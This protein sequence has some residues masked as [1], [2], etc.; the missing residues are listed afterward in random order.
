MKVNLIPK[1]I[2]VLTRCNTIFA[3]VKLSIGNKNIAS[4]FIHGTK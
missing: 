3:L 4:N 1:P 2:S